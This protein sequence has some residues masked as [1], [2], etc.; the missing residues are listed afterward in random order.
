MMEEINDL[1]FFFYK[2]TNGFNPTT[3]FSK[4]YLTFEHYKDNGQALAVRFKNLFTFDGTLLDTPDKRPEDLAASMDKLVRSMKEKS[5]YTGT[6]A[7]EG[8]LVINLCR[9]VLI[10]L[11]GEVTLEKRYAKKITDND[12]Q[13]ATAEHIGMGTKTTW[14]GTPDL[15]VKGCPLVTTT[16]PL[17]ADEE[18]TEDMEDIENSPQS[19]ASPPQ[20]ASPHSIGSSTNIESKLE[21]KPAHLDQLITTS[22]VAAFIEHRIHPLQNPLIPTILINRKGFKI[23]LYDPKDDILLISKTKNILKKGS[24]SS[25][26][27]LLLWIVVHHR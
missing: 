7:T 4:A 12:L 5:P 2:I 3:P 6:F 11:F 23:C 9:D 19:Q 10:P 17:V 27:L 20:Q 21:M 13:G 15:R 14:H 8:E 1:P 26:G 22:V 18:M 25:S 16:V 24:L